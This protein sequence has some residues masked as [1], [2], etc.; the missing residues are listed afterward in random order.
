RRVLSRDTAFAPART[1]WRARRTVANGDTGWTARHRDTRC[2]TAVGNRPRDRRGRGLGG[3]KHR[4]DP[5]RY[6]SHCRGG[7]WDRFGGHSRM[8]D[9]TP[10]IFF[11]VAIIVVIVLMRTIKIV[12]QKQVKI[13]ERLGKDHTGDAHHS[14]TRARV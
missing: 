10:L 11:G 5:D 7:G 14:Y 1:A 8:I 13:I 9:I 2:R 12:P 6:K 4:S 3:A